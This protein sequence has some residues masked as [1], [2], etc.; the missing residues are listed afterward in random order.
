[1][2]YMFIDPAEVERAVLR[3]NIEQSEREYAG[4]SVAFTMQTT[5]AADTTNSEDERV[6]YQQNATSTKQR[7]DQLEKQLTSF[8]N[9][10]NALPAPAAAAEEANTPPKATSTK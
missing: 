7:M 10:F 4:L 9:Q 5:L 3:N 2:D 8:K 6:A 1:M